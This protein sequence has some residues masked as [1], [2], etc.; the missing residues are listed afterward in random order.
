MEKKQQTSESSFEASADQKDWPSKSHIGPNQWLKI[1]RKYQLSRREIDVCKYICRGCSN[2]VLAVK[3][4]ITE[5]TVETYI[6]KIYI[7]VGVK[8]KITL[9]LR[10]LES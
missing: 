10:F 1:Q 5:N 2:K 8:S 9:L 3:L 6:G 4:G 7:K